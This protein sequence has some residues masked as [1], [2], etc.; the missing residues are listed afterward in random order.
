MKK[1]I[2]LL[3]FV[4]TIGLNSCIKN[5]DIEH[6]NYAYSTVYFGYQFP[7]RTLILGDYVYDNANDN[8]HQ[9]VISAHLGGLLSNKHDK[10]FAVSVDNSLCNGLQFSGTKEPILALPQNY[11]EPIATELIIPKGKMSGGV[12]VK[13]TDAF[14]NDPMAIRN[15]YVIALRLTNPNHAVDSVL[16]GNKTD[17]NPNPDPRFATEWAVGPKDF[18]MFVVKYVNE[19]YG[20]YFQWG[21]SKTNIAGVTTDT[22]YK[23]RWVEYNPAL[24]LTTTGR[25]TVEGSFI[26]KSRAMTGTIRMTLTFSGAYDGKN[27]CT[28]SGQGTT[29]NYTY[30]VSGTGSFF[31]SEAGS[32]N[33]FGNKNRNGIKLNYNVNLTTN[34]GGSMT[35]TAED[36]LVLRS[37]DIVMEIYTP[38][39]Q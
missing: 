5:F 32:Y 1:I 28:I 31:N 12:T 21:T 18:T 36:E 10:K 37:R 16:V 26:L 4:V 9:F 34:D 35:Y 15:K 22:I 33:G 2:I 39:K 7:V 30:M 38:E 14:F 11:Y 13:L 25:N 23:H 19:F 3:L 20:A 17:Q 6:D 27:N 24:T 8:A 29:G